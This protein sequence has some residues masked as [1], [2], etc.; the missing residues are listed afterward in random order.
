MLARGIMGA[1]AGALGGPW[2]MAIGFGTGVI[3]GAIGDYVGRRVVEAVYDEITTGL[4]EQAQYT[5]THVVDFMLNQ[6]V[7]SSFG[8]LR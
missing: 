8:P 6:G 5:S 2:G 7:Y 1:E 3:G 4:N